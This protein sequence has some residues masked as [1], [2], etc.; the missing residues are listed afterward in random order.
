MPLAQGAVE[1]CSVEKEWE[2]LAVPKP[3]PLAAGARRFPPS[4]TCLPL[5]TLPSHHSLVLSDQ[6]GYETVL[7]TYRVLCILLLLPSWIPS[8]GIQEA[9]GYEPKFHGSS[10]YWHFT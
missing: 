7:G 6:I 2:A 5:F 9:T 3:L 10:A 8:H 1:W 4:F